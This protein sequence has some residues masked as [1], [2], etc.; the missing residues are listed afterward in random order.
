VCVSKQAASEAVGQ[1]ERAISTALSEQNTR[2]THLIR[3]R[4]TPQ[5]AQEQ[6]IRHTEPRPE[7]RVGYADELHPERE[8]L[9]RLGRHEVDHRR[10]LPSAS[11]CI[12]DARS[13]T[14]NEVVGAADRP[15]HLLH[16]PLPDLVLRQVVDIAQLE[17]GMSGDLAS[18]FRRTQYRAWTD[19][20]S[21]HRPRCGLAGICYPNGGTTLTRLCAHL[22]HE[23]LLEHQSFL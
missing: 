3:R 20:P 2:L 19:H 5:S 11:S 14:K 13:T 22:G 15:T 4:P 1:Q 12:T 18:A 7:G 8:R 16:R 17:R 23:L 10:E 9:E 21:S 6:P